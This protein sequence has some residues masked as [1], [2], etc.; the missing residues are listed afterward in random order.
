MW[1]APVEC[2]REMV[3]GVVD[4]VDR[5]AAV[6]FTRFFALFPAAV[7]RACVAPFARAAFADSPDADHPHEHTASHRSVARRRTRA[8]CTRVPGLRQ[9]PRSAPP[10]VSTTPRFTR[11]TSL[12]LPCV[13]ATWQ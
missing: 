1:A 7:V 11:T 8:R 9:R 5:D 2:D 4:F 10:A 12:M 13:I 6:G 3:F